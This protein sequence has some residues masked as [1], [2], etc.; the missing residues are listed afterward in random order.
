LRIHCG[1]RESRYDSEA[2]PV[3]GVCSFL[4]VLSDSQDEGT[5]TAEWLMYI[6]ASVLIFLGKIFPL[7]NI[8]INKRERRIKAA[9]AFRE[10][11]QRELTGLYPIPTEWPKGPGIEKRLERI[12]PSLQAAVTVYEPFIS[13]AKQPRFANAWLVFY[14]AYNREGEQCYHHYMNFGTDTVNVA[15]GITHVKQ[16]GK[17]NFKRNVDRVLAF[18]KDT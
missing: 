8:W 9:V 12:F 16:N 5:G 3:L 15:G 10:T 18:A 6:P 1:R 7:T 11:F 13:K 14:N 17:K 2:C 4:S